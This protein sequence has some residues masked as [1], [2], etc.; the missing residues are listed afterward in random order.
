MNKSNNQTDINPENDTEDYFY[1]EKPKKKTRKVKKAK[2]EEPTEETQIT[3]KKKNLTEEV[4]F[5]DEVPPRLLQTEPND[6]EPEE[7]PKK[8]KKK[9]IKKKKKV[10]Q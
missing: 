5:S 1:H 7:E 6:E 2:Q 8:P 3:H 9:K 4:E 10:K